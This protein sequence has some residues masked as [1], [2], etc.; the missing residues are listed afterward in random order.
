MIFLP[1]TSYASYQPPA[2]RARSSVTGGARWN[3][4]ETETTCTKRSNRH[5]SVFSYTRTQLELRPYLTYKF[6]L[7]LNIIFCFLFFFFKSTDTA[8]PLTKLD[9]CSIALKC[10]FYVDKLS[11]YLLRTPYLIFINWTNV[12]VNP[13]LP[14]TTIQNATKWIPRRACHLVGNFKNYYMCQTI[15]KNCL[16]A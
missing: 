9:V 13:I 12:C 8:P 16:R 14:A 4:V 1:T 10:V 15:F 3:Q 2:T 7:L 11:L 5:R 6:W